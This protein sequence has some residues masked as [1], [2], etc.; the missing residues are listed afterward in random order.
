MREKR[1]L[2]RHRQGIERPVCLQNRV[3]ENRRIEGGILKIKR[4][5]DLRIG[6]RN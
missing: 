2:G 5:V 1:R 3:V 4:E 6:D